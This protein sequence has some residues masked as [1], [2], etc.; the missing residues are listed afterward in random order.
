MVHD[1]DTSLLLTAEEIDPATF[2]VIHKFSE[3]DERI[4]RKL[5]AHGPVL[6]QG[7]RGT[8][9]SALLIAA[10]L[11]MAPHNP[12]SDV[13]GLYVSLRYVPLLKAE[14]AEYER[15]FCK[16]VSAQISNSLEKLEV[17]FP[18][19]DELLGLRQSLASLSSMTGKRIVL[20]FDDAAHIGRETSLSGFFDLF[21]TISSDT[22]SC[23]AAIYPG[24]TEFGSRFDIYNDAT[25]VDVLRSPDQ[26]GF[27]R[28]FAEIMRARYPEISESRIST[29]GFEKFST[30]IATSVLGNVRGF[31]FACNDIVEHNEP[32]ASLGYNALTASM[33]RL[34]ADYYWPLLEEVKPKLGKYTAAADTAHDIAEVIFPALGSGHASSVLIHKQHVMRLSKPLE[35]LEY[36]GF[37]AR[38]QASRAMKSGGRGALYAVNL[39]NLLERVPGSRLTASVAELWLSSSVEP[40]EIHERSGLLQEISSPEPVSGVDL[41][42]FDLP[43]DTL[44]KS[45]AYPY[46]LTDLK[47]KRLGK[48]GFATVGD[49]VEA[50]D[51]D[52]L[53]IESVGEQYLKQIR[54]VLA[55]AIWM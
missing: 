29:F 34:A 25:V 27:S 1:A 35:I 55:Q 11:R 8:G 54:S 7:G 19:S 13:L 28:Q 32:D 24:V 39:C 15:L 51:E 2:S 43:I 20:L 16:W 21:R 18:R 10:G 3:H 9:K 46:G 47:I 45:R 41:A 49:M 30:F 17:E 12:E 50:K 36:V 37:I 40:M 23:K 53:K 5:I 52:L 26:V 44:R 42:I 33:Q 38:R 31:I 48:A 6:L 22:I 14:G 4:L